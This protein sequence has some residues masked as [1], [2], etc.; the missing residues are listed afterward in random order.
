[1]ERKPKILLIDDDPDFVEATSWVLKARPYQILVAYNGTA[2][3][4]K[5][6]EENPDLILLD[7]MMPEKDG[8]IVADELSRDPAMANIPVLALTSFSEA[9]GPPPFPFRVSEYLDK[10]IKPDELL[11]MID[12]HLKRLGFAT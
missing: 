1:M 2:G 6:K 11:N 4:K 8:F 10:S 12:K 3:L 9:L 7:I 5:V